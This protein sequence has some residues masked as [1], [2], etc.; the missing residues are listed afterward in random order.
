VSGTRTIGEGRGWV[1]E[2]SEEGTVYVTTTVD[3]EDAV[4]LD[5]RA[6]VIA[7]RDAL[8]AW[9]AETEPAPCAHASVSLLVVAM[10]QSRGSTCDD[11]GRWFPLTSP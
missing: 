6:E 3:Y 2:E 1:V 4:A 5:D 11:C 10:G 9:V 7:L 8:S